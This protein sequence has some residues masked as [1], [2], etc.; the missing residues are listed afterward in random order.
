MDPANAALR[1]GIV[2]SRRQYSVP[3]PNSLWHLD[4]YH[5]LIRWGLAIHGWID[6]FSRRIMFLRC[7]TNNPSQ[8]ALELFSESN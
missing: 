1:W 2:V 4:G 3:R 6:G 8:T 7:S 5:F